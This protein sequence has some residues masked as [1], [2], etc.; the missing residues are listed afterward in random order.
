MTEERPASIRET[1]N[2]LNNEQLQS[3]I[4]WVDSRQA[5]RRVEPAVFQPV[6]PVQSDLAPASPAVVSPSP[7]EHPVPREGFIEQINDS[8]ANATEP[9]GKV[10]VTPQALALYLQ[11]LRP[12]DA[13][14]QNIKIEILNGRS[15]RAK[16]KISKMGTSDF[17]VMLGADQDG[18]ELKV[19]STG[20]TNVALTHRG[21]TGNIT[22]HLGNLIPTLQNQLDGQIA[23]KTWK[24]AGFSIHQDGANFVISFSKELTVQEKEQKEQN[25]VRGEL[26]KRLG[27]LKALAGR[28][29]LERPRLIELASEWF[30]DKGFSEEQLEEYAGIQRKN[31]VGWISAGRVYPA[32]PMVK[33]LFDLLH[34]GEAEAIKAII[35]QKLAAAGDEPW[36]SAW[37]EYLIPPSTTEPAAQ[38]VPSVARRDALAA[39]LPN[40]QPDVIEGIA[41]R[42]RQRVEPFARETSEYILGNKVL[43]TDDVWHQI[44]GALTN[45]ATRQALRDQIAARVEELAGRKEF[46]NQEEQAWR[47]AW[48]KELQPTPAVLSAEVTDEDLAGEIQ[49]IVGE[50]DITPERL[51]EPAAGDGLPLGGSVG[52]LVPVRIPPEW[53]AGETISG[54]GTPYKKDTL[55]SRYLEAVDRRASAPQR[56]Y[57]LEEA[58]RR[59]RNS[60]A[61]AIARGIPV[62]DEVLKDYPDLVPSAKK[63]T[64][65]VPPGVTAD[66]G[67]APV[68]EEPT[69]GGLE[70]A[71]PARELELDIDD[72]HLSLTSEQVQEIQ[73]LFH[74]LQQL[75]LRN[76]DFND[77]Y[78]LISRQIE[79]MERQLI[80]TLNLPQLDI[81]ITEEIVTRLH[82]FPIAHE[83]YL[84]GSILLRS[85][86]ELFKTL[87]SSRPGLQNALNEVLGAPDTTKYMEFQKLTENAAGI[88]E[89]NRYGGL[90]RI[91]FE[92]G[93]RHPE[94][95]TLGDLIVLFVRRKQYSA[96]AD[97]SSLS[98][99]EKLE[100]FFN[101]L[102]A[103]QGYKIIADQRSDTSYSFKL[104]KIEP[105]SILVPDAET[106]EVI[107]PEIAGDPDLTRI[108]ND[109]LEKGGSEMGEK[110]LESVRLMM[111]RNPGMDLRTAALRLIKGEQ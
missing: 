111:E 48:E 58:R 32:D 68:V 71:L 88:D 22:Q 34:E 82:A 78:V 54:I 79:D 28:L 106:R 61:D 85:N 16:G 38:T 99:R 90:E 110:F 36:A 10:F 7:P 73:G 70:S 101:N 8:L 46:P 94:R 4:S 108:Y 59:H 21:Q 15:V 75:Y 87:F 11:E 55:L 76:N 35:G 103:E 98:R 97:Q 66:A 89:Y 23:D 45:E 31:M 37:R 62:P 84:F 20:L 72:I 39:Q 18:G 9:T 14:L 17:V 49:R 65:L 92:A 64:Q 27:N 63:E 24:A 44:N 47:E 41:Q 6:T 67:S 51:A 1:L 13:S 80:N 93:L 30:K 60:V 33:E 105:A 43:P 107:L 83:F 77:D 81:G 96:Q 52:E 40:L 5:D 100:V 53:L 102:A 50:T 69:G 2:A 29:G 86:E 56:Q 74:Q 95:V 57:A 26:G 104:E 3:V 42:E 19:V 12:Q 91:Q 109:I 25:E